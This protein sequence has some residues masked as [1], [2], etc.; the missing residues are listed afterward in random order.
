MSAQMLC[1]GGLGQFCSIHQK[2]VLYYI[3]KAKALG[4]WRSQTS[5][6][7]NVP[8]VPPKSCHATV[9]R[10]QVIALRFSKPRT[11]PNE[12]PFQM[13]L[14]PMEL[15]CSACTQQGKGPEREPN[16]TQTWVGTRTQS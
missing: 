8:V 6:G 5:Q 15:T 16:M 13:R 10:R 4:A 2:G 11:P 14:N 1:Q 9:H 7:T 3:Y 12:T